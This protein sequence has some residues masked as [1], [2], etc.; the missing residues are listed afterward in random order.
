MAETI[1]PTRPDD[2]YQPYTL[3]GPT[4]TRLA[5][6]PL[7]VNSYIYIQRVHYGTYKY[8]PQAGIDPP[9]QREFCYQTTALP[10]SHHGWTFKCFVTKYGFRMQGKKVI[11]PF[12]FALENLSIEK[13]FLKYPYSELLFLSIAKTIST[14]LN[15]PLNQV[16]IPSPHQHTH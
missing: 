1:P 4:V 14:L 15:N 10:P 3:V 8:I 9:R 6:D 7:A 12:K 16:C 5:Q 2:K 11:P 13:Q